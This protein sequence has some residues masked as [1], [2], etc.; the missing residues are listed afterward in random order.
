MRTP[1]TST[2]KGKRVRIKTA[3][4]EIIIGKFMEKRSGRVLLEDRTV[5]VAD[6]VSFGIYKP[7][8]NAA[9]ERQSR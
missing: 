2:N 7:R 6:I 9:A 4:G 8:P 5:S 3:D 1:H